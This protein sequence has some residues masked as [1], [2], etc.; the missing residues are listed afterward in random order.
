MDAS[1]KVQ[2]HPLDEPDVHGNTFKK[3][4]SMRRGSRVRP[5]ANELRSPKVG[6]GA[7]LR[8][9]SLQPA[10]MQHHIIA[11][12]FSTDNTSK[13]SQSNSQGSQLNSKDS[14]DIPVCFCA[15]PMNKTLQRT[16]CFDGLSHFFLAHSDPSPR[17]H[18]HT[19][20]WIGLGARTRSSRAKAN[21]NHI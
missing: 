5:G 17:S 21:K 13:E 15:R 14:L 2:V 1:G 11:A 9:G 3:M 19:A 7:S 12:A 16:Q 6:R 8:R 4:S 20:S 10:E 18:R